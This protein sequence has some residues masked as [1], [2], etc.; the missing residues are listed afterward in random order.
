M[1]SLKISSLKHEEF[2]LPFNVLS[3]V[4]TQIMSGGL[5][6]GFCAAQTPKAD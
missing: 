3:V 4:W 6:T 2:L 5:E 1:L